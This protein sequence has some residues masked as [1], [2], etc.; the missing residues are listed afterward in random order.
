MTFYHYK[1]DFQ[2]IYLVLPENIFSIEVY[3]KST[4]FHFE[5]N[6]HKFSGFYEKN[7]CKKKKVRINYF[8][9]QG[10]SMNILKNIPEKKTKISKPF[11]SFQTIQN[12]K[13]SFF[14]QS[15]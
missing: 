6:L 2:K 15:W 4:W 5:L 1:I 11:A 8:D 3:S 10:C 7:P 13:F 14:G 12:L 9:E